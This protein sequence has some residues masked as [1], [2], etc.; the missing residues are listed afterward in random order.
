MDNV[1]HIMPYVKSV[2]IETAEKALVPKKAEDM[3]NVLFVNFCIPGSKLM[4]TAKQIIGKCLDFISSSPER[5]C[6]IIIA[7]NTASRWIK[8][9]K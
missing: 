4:L 6:A 8:K 2:I 9:C 5:T 3:F 7:P 1:D